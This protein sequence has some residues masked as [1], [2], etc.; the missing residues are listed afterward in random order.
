[1]RRLV[2][3]DPPEVIPVG[4]DFGLQRQVRAAG[5]DQVDARQPVLLGYLL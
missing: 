4:E 3:E 5:I 1:M 2:E